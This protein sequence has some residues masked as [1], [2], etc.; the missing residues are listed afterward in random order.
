MLLTDQ[1]SISQQTDFIKMNK[2][3]IPILQ[4]D[5]KTGSFSI[6]IPS[7]SSISHNA[8]IL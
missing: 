3:I 5:R 4:F 6:L 1:D 2:T 8:D 7:T